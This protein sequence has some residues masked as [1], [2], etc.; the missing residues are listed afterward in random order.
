MEILHSTLFAMWSPGPMEFIIIGIVLLLVFGKK[1][2]ET[3]RELGKSLVEFKK[4]LR[5][6]GIDDTNPTQHVSGVEEL[7]VT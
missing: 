1:L 7:D 6:E 2:P 4:G 3:A 5:G